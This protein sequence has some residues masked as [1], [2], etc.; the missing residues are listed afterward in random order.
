MKKIFIKLFI[1][2]FMSSQFIGSEEILS[3][4]DHKNT[5][6]I[7]YLDL[8]KYNRRFKAEVRHVN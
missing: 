8:I 6:L 7:K 4:V 1:L 5:N 3:T 2:V